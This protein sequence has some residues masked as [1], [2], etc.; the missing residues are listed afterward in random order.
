[1]FFHSFGAESLQNSKGFGNLS[2]EKKDPRFASK[3][4][5]ITSGTAGLLDFVRTIVHAY[6]ILWI[7]WLNP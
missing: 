7:P 3:K 6:L 4:K 2:V 1:M 5:K